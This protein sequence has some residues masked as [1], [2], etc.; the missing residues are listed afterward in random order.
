MRRV[1]SAMLVLGVGAALWGG[2]PMR[3]YWGRSIDWHNARDLAGGGTARFDGGPGAVFGRPAR[4]GFATDPAIELSFGLRSANEQR[5]RTVYDRFENAIGEAVVADNMHLAEL[6]G[7]LAVSWP[8]FGMGA[9]GV[10][11]AP[12]LDF[13]YEYSK[14]FRDD[15]YNLIGEDRV[16]QTGMVYDA[17]LG[18]GFRPLGWLSIGAGGAYRFGSRDLQGHTIRYPDTTRESESGNP[19]GFAWSGGLALRPLARLVLDVGY[20]GGTEL[21]GWTVDSLAG[22]VNRA[23]PW[24]ALVGIAY[25]APGALPSRVT[26]EV[27][28]TAWSGVDTSWSNVITA[29]A[30]VEHT[31]LNSI[32]LRYGFGVEPLAFDPTVQVAQVGVGLGFDPGLVLIDVGALFQRDVIGAGLFHGDLTPDDQHV[33]E[34]WTTFAVTISRRF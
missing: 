25:A 11:F 7:P 22:D 17:A 10:G 8:L 13:S 23:Q 30:G 21:A 18:L 16:E 33:Y 14:E 2:M 27:A 26:G 15:F 12:V 1:I 6:P 19:A 20:N 28:Y 34:T 5:T 3:T 4:L 32:K 31:M 9:V 29:R 24:V